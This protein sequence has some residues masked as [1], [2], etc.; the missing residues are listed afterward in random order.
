MG[1]YFVWVDDFGCCFEVVFL[2][3]VDFG[4]V[5]LVDQGVVGFFDFNFRVGQVYYL[6]VW[7]WLFGYMDIELVNMYDSWLCLLYLE[8]LVVVF[9]WVVFW[10]GEGVW[11]FLV[12][13]CMKYWCGYYIW[14]YC[15]GV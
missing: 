12:E 13:V 15:F 1:G 4:L 5:L 14:V 3:L 6:L 2:M 7:K 8:D 11:N 10:W 9:D